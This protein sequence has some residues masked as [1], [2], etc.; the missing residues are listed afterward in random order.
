MTEQPP[1]DVSATVSDPRVRDALDAIDTAELV[2]QL[3]VLLT[4]PSVT[5]SA[6]ESAAQH[7]LAEQCRQAG[8]DVDLWPIDLPEVTAD[9]G[10][11]GMEAARSEAWGMV[12]THHGGSDGP[13]VVLNGHIDVVPTGELSDWSVD[14]W[15]AQIRDGVVL[16]RGAADMKAGL[17][18]QLAAVVALRRANFRLRGRVALW[19]VVGEEDGGLGTFATLR[20]G[21]TGE[22][23]VIAEPTDLAVVPAA[24]G[25]LTFRLT[26]PGRSAHASV[27]TSGVDAMDHYLRVHQALRRLEAER[28]ANPDPLMARWDLAWPLSVGTVRAGTWPSSVPDRVVAEGRL[29]VALGE[30]VIDARS[31]LEAAISQLSDGD[32]WLGSHPVT[33]EWFGGQFAPGAVDAGHPVVS[34]VSDAHEALHGER[35]QLHGV[36]YGSD[37][38]LLGA[39]GIPTVHYGPGRLRAAHA[40]DESVPIDQLATVTRTLVL[41]VAAAC[42]TR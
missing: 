5:G 7:L 42:G 30:S 31:Q 29:G 23:A 38:R 16:G 20:R 15:S 35:P 39:A 37:L 14:P 32:P 4:V 6:A 10:F 13:T 36:P 18:C 2:S 11:P 24:A 21:H 33:V 12:A 1:A 25:A 34:L 27:R 8:L 22:L 3:Q 17:V 28:N 26:V 19:S 9:P 40:P 41:T